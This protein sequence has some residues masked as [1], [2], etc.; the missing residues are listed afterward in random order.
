MIVRMTITPIT[1]RSLLSHEE[2]K[3]YFRRAPTPYRS[4]TPQ[5]AVVAIS[6]EGKYGKI[7]R[8]TF[9]E[10]FVKGKELL[11]RDD[12]RDISIF[13][14]NRIAPVPIFANELMTPA[15]DWCGRCRRPSH[16]RI[17]GRTHPALRDAPVIVSDVRRCYFCGISMEYVT[18]M[19]A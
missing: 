17:Y 16:F 15:D 10:A 19:V 2:Y 7:T 8:P 6:H 5:W 1:L 3:E 13:C 9:K 18:T 14:R 4:S 11:Q 12:I